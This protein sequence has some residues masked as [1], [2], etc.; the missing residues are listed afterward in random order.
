[1]KQLFLSF[2]AFG[3]GRF[4]ME[5]SK[6]TVCVRKRK[7]AFLGECIVDNECALFLRDSRGLQ[8]FQRHLERQ[9]IY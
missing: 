9:F 4:R 3:I 8:I 1:M 5:K 6:L 2:N 7:C